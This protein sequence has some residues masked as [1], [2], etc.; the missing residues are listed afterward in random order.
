MNA[1]Q[2]RTTI[3]LVIFDELELPKGLGKIECLAGHFAHVGFQVFLARRFAVL[4][5][6]LHAFKVMLDVEV[7][8]CIPPCP[9]G[10][11][12]GFLLEPR[13]GQEA[14]LDGRLKLL[15]IELFLEHHD[16]DDH[17]QVSRVFHA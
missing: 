13:I 10:V 8:V 17:H 16:A 6:E 3:A 14:L 1:G 9:G 11:L 12:Y 7:P 2:K 4:P 5:I 15:E